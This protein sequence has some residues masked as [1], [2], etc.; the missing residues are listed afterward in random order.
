MTKENFN[1]QFAPKIDG[2][3]NS[4]FVP[5][6]DGL[7]NSQFVPK[8]DGLLKNRY[9][10][11]NE[12]KLGSVVYKVHYDRPISLEKHY[13]IEDMIEYDITM[14]VS[15]EIQEKVD[16]N[17]LNTLYEL[18]AEHSDANELVVIDKSEF[19]KFVELCLPIYYLIKGCE[20]HYEDVDNVVRQFKDIVTFI[21]DISRRE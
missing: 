21:T 17:I 1:S 19:K 10:Y 16:N 4:Q 20:E 5:K 12:N 18:Y 13:I 3:L 9:S 15:T 6:I 14:K 2:L 8:I 11:S 7:L